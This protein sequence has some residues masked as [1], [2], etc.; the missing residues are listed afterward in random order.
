MHALEIL[1]IVCG[2]ALSLLGVVKAV[3]GWVRWGAALLRLLAQAVEE[4]QHLRDEMIH[5]RLVQR[6]DT[7]RITA[8]EQRSISD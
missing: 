8:L 5:L 2:A 3:A 6:R 4:L 7:R 1:G